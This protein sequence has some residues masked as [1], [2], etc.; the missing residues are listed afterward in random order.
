MARR[1]SFKTV[2]ASVS[3]IAALAAV[4]FAVVRQPGVIDTV[5][6]VDAF[7]LLKVVPDST[8]PRYAGVY[9][10]YHANSA[11]TAIAIWILSGQQP[12]VGSMAPVAGDPAMVWTGNPDALH[13]EWKPYRDRLSIEVDGTV[14]TREGPTAIED[15]YFA[16][17]RQS[18]LAC[19]DPKKIELR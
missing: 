13:A 10:Y 3:V 1:M 11:S 8:N 5:D 4:V 2:L 16:E 18:N 15:C 7:E 19:L 12:S 9:R 17:P 6:T 14:N